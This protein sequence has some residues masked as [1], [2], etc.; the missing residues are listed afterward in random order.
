MTK[1]KAILD[2]HNV[3][4]AALDGD[5]RAKAEVM[6]SLTTSD[7]PILLGRSFNA[8]LLAAYEALTPVWGSYATRTT[9]ANFKPQPFK[10]ILG[11]TGLDLVPEATEYP[12]TGLSESMYEFKVEKYGKRLPLTWEMLVNDELGAFRNIHQ[13]L[14]EAARELEGTVTTKALLK[15]DLKDVETG[16]FK[17]A[18]GNAPESAPLT[19]KALQDAIQEV[20]TRKTPD[21]KR[22][23]RP[24]LVLVVPPTLEMTAREILTA[25]EI[26]RTDQ[27]GNETIVSS[28]PVANAVTLVVEPNLLLNTH[29]AAATTWFLLPAPNQ[30]RPALVTGFLQGHETPDLRVKNDQGTRI[31][32]GSITESEGSFVDDTIEYR[33]R[34]VVGSSLLDPLHTFVSRG[35]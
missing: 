20:T 19:R 5:F 1:N 4:Q 27:T 21:G 35:A 29:T 7:F 22:V 8:K 11:T 34:H 2:A 13:V 9:V 14:A 10:Q 3:F 32:G 12:A 30:A 6:E 33:V 18:N 15:G 28:N 16:F 25:S 17:T 24:A 23:S 31:G 26:R